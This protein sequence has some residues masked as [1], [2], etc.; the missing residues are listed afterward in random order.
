MKQVWKCDFCSTHD[1]DADVVQQHELKCVFNPIMK[2]C[3]TCKNW[4]ERYQDCDKELDWCN[5]EDGN[6]KGW[7]G[8]R[9][10]TL[11]M[12]IKDL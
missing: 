4:N 2:A 6:C 3:F 12:L 11:A 5:G 9:K 8:F 1:E 10:D 7:Q